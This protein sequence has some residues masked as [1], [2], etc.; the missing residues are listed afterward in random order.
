MSADRVVKQQ[1]GIEGGCLEA[2]GA[3]CQGY[4]HHLNLSNLQ[5]CLKITQVEVVSLTCMLSNLVLRS[6]RHTLSVGSHAL[7]GLSLILICSW[8]LT[9]SRST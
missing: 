8:S 7:E 2:E 3:K 5:T 6:S 4:H 1:V 9:M